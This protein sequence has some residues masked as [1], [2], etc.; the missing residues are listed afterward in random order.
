MGWVDA[1]FVLVTLAAMM[2]P[3]TLTFSVLAL[4]LGDRPR[5]TG[6]WFYLGAL[7]VTLAIGVI[8]A[9]VLGDHAASD[10]PSEPRTWVAVLDVVAA[11][12]LLGWLLRSLRRPPDRK[13][14]EGMVA[15][16]GNV[17]NSR[18]IAII[19]A[20]ATL[21]NPGGFIPIALKDISETDPTA[22]QF[23]VDWVF[24]SLVSLLPLA[25]ALVMLLVAPN[26][27]RRVLHGARDW[28][29]RNVRN[30]MAVIIVLLAAS[31]LRNGIAGLVS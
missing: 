23:I 19:G 21:A 31:L 8:A 25:T 7:S 15:Q 18:V 9:F 22:T 24:F 12:L 28:L 20:G 10:A 13:R 11:A 4:V 2:S 26:P 6:V 29:V 14:V 16:M 1:E 17:A 3:T 30:V 27:T 5:R